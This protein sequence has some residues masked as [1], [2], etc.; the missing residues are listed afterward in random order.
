MRTGFGFPCR[1][2]FRKNVMGKSVE[3]DDDDWD[4]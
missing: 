3:T 1:V 4:F 2:P